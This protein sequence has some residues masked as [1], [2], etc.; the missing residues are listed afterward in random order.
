M[1]WITLGVILAATLFIF[2]ELQP[3]LLFRNTTPSGGDMGGHVWGPMYLKRHLLPHG[4]ITGW[5]PDWY[6]GFPYLVFYFPV[7]TLG[8]ALLSYVLPYGV[9]FKLVTVLGLLTLPLAA[10]AMGKLAKMRDPVPLCLAVAMVPFVFDRTW[11]IYGGNIASTLAGEFAFSISLS[12]ALVFLGVYA[13]GMRTGKGRALSPALLALVAVCHIV[14]AFFALGG[15]AVLTLLYPDRRRFGYMLSTFA[16]AGL[17]AAFWIVPF[18]LRIAYTNDMGW[19]KIVLYRHTLIPPSER[20]LVVLALCGS[21][22]GLLLRRRSGVFLTLLA[23]GSALAF[24]FAPQS[25]LWN[26]RLLPFWMLSLYL[27]V[28]FLV[29]EAGRGLAWALEDVDDGLRIDTGPPLAADAGVL[30]PDR[31]GVDDEDDIGYFGGRRPADDQAD[32]AEADDAA[33]AGAGPAASTPSRSGLIAIWATPV[34]ALLAALYMVA[35]P[36][37][38]L[39]RAPVPLRWLAIKTND[40]SF[41]PDWVRWNYT[42]YEGKASYPEYK[43]LTTTMAAVGHDHGCGRAMWEY[44]P[45]L[46]RLGT[47]MALMLLP[48][49]TNGCIGSMEGLFF[50]SSATTPYHFLNQAE[51]SARPSSAQRDLPYESLSGAGGP[52]VF[53][54]GVHHLQLLGVRYYMALSPTVQALAHGNP[55]LQLLTTSGPWDVTYDGKV[56]ARTWE[57]YQVK[58]SDMVTGLRF[59]PAVVKGLAKGGKPWLKAA[60]DWYQDESRWDVPLAVSGPPGWPGVSRPVANP[61]RVPVAPAAVSNVVVGDDRISFDVD[62]VGSPVLVKAS[63]FPNW[64]ASGAKGVWRVTPNLMV[65]VPTS[66]HVS[67]HYGDTPVDGLAWGLTLLGL[68]ALGWLLWWGRRQEPFDSPADSPAAAPA[69]D[70]VVE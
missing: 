14:P 1:A 19:E 50:E 20:W 40:R 32:G 49:W 15:A 62:R 29:A 21:V 16:V 23:A 69:A 7:P 68:V 52:A 31:L 24:R 37:H 34:V 42:G 45:E 38:L 2:K 36:L 60:V 48:F 26:A 35:T 47:P 70:A 33:L 12:L 44:E 39:D 65:V 22:V 57:I 5:T 41:I 17:L 11:T 58:G 51:L 6:D 28:G 55:D 8:I 53:A 30:D 56:Q 18:Q 4:R 63:Y 25:R 46:D 3:H 59:D 61:P 64:Q 54:K 66:R 13:R 10:W 9:A 43:S 27:L 67:L